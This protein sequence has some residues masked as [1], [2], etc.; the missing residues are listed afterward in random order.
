MK[1]IIKKGLATLLVAGLGVA[2]LAGCTSAPKTSS[3]TDVMSVASELDSYSYS[4]E[5]SYAM[6]ESTSMDV[7]LYGNCTKDAVSMSVKVKTEGIDST[8]YDITAKDIIICT[9]D[10]L[11]VNV[12]EVEEAFLAEMDLG[13]YGIDADWIMLDY[14]MEME[15]ETS[16][17]L[18]ETFLE[19]FEAAYEDLIDEDDGE[20]TLVIDDNDT[21]KEF[22]EATATM[23]DENSEEWADLM[24]SMYDDFDYQA[25]I[26]NFM[27]SLFMEMNKTFDLGMTASDIS[28][29]VDEAL[30]EM[31]FSE[32]EVDA[33]Y[34]TEML[35]GLVTDINE[36][37]EYVDMEGAEI[38]I[39]ASQDGSE[40]VTKAKISYEDTYYEE[41]VVINVTSTIVAE[42][43][44][45][46]VPSE[47]DVQTVENAICA[48]IKQFGDEVSAEDVEEL[49]NSMD[50]LLYEVDIEDMMSSSMSGSMSGMDEYYDDYEWDEEW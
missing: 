29:G 48:V 35:D 15:L 31:D 2:A 25:F 46:S 5:L 49:M 34:Y 7:E 1:K 24:V 19:D 42:D 33:S 3:M 40:Y 23:L 32:L 4:Y 6:G 22:L 14:G 36:S 27:N 37:I 28:A 18:S 9:K 12:A 45:V 26:S 16:T 47:D 20:Y 8:D 50:D 17:E 21:A 13:T 10:A 39:T 44:K 11:Y 30:A 43:V 38:E 41:K